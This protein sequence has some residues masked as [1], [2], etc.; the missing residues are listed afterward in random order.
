MQSKSGFK[1]VYPMVF[2]LF[3][4][5]GRLCR[6]AMR[7]QVRSMIH[8][9][10]HGIAV[11]GLASEVNKLSLAERRELMEWVIEDTAGVVPVTVTIAEPSV[12]AQIEF[13]RAA[14]AAGAAWVILQ[15]PPVKGVPER[16]LIRFFG[17]V[18]EQ[19]SLPVGIQNAPEYLGIGLSVDGL[20]ELHHVHPNVAI[21]KLEAPAL[22]IA[23]LMESLDGAVDIF[24]GR[25]GIEI[26]D[27]LRAGAVGI[28]PG[29][30]AF[31]V[32]VR[33]Y[34]ALTAVDG[35]RR[36]GQRLYAELLP[37]LTFLMESI[38]TFLV[39]GKQ[40][41]GER[42]KLSERDPRAPWTPPL[43]FGLEVARDYAAALGP[44]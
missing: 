30:E 16:E 29:G 19:S 28:I 43:R 17:A 41:F 14:A 39:Y 42:L 2:A 5:S 23:R 37:M 3:D 21:L 18:A 34:E 1:G 20:K 35:D 13:T 4:T 9:K 36:E 8:H 33:I 11:L 22:T 6:E 38:D 15:P 7:A 25:D 12:S 32:L 10:V 27:S 31:D 40:V 44:L 24:N 26:V